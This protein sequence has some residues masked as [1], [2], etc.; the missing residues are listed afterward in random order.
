MIGRSLFTHRDLRPRRIRGPRST[1]RAGRHGSRRRRQ[2]RL[3]DAARR[4]CRGIVRT[5]A[6]VGAAPGVVFGAR[7]DN[8]GVALHRRGGAAEIS[9]RN[10]ALGPE[11]GRAELV[12]PPHMETNDGV[13]FIGEPAARP[14]R[15]PSTWRPSDDIVRDAPVAVMK[16]DVEGAELGVL[17][18][19]RRALG[20][21]RITHVVFED[22]VGADSAVART[23][24]ANG[25]RILSVGWSVRGLRLGEDPERATGDAVRSSSFIASLEPDEVMDA[26]RAPGWTTLSPRSAFVDWSDMSVQAL[27]SGTSAALLERPP[28]CRARQ[29]RHERRRH[30]RCRARE[31]PCD[32]SEWTRAR[33]RRRHGHIDRPARCGR[34]CLHADRR[35]PA[36]QARGAAQRRSSGSRPISMLNCRVRMRRSTP[37]SRPR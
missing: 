4:R 22:H 2:R 24:I 28:L 8:V 34:L 12:M 13:A 37:S 17:A 29:P 3:H 25:Y 6:V 20:E 33:V 7:S 14:D 23:L 11:A 36:A 30:L 21:G 15:R 35:G 1:D 32:E 31:C 19:A 5:R 26:C 18:G 10:A 9:I 16:L 27:E